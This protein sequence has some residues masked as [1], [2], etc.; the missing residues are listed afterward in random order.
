MT[1]ALPAEPLSWPDL[2]RQVTALEEAS[3]LH[4][5]LAKAARTAA[6]QGAD[7]LALA[8]VDDTGAAPRL[9]LRTGVFPPAWRAAWV[10][11]GPLGEGLARLAVEADG[12]FPLGSPM[13]LP[14]AEEDACGPQVRKGEVFPYRRPRGGE[15]D[16]VLVAGEALRD[17]PEAAAQHRLLADVF[18][19]VASARLNR[20][21]PRPRL[22]ARQL[23]CL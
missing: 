23:A 21:R 13:P 22:T 19:A 14:F 4:D 16:L 5:L 12:P 20:D 1:A 15:I 18:R 9:I 7:L 10:A 2:A 3:D 17:G 8:Q 11:Q 6:R